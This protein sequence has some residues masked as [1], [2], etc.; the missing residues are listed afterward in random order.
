MR[1]NDAFPWC[2]FDAMLSALLQHAEHL[3]ARLCGAARKHELIR[4][5]DSLE[6]AGCQREMCAPWKDAVA[7]HKLLLDCVQR[8]RRKANFE[9]DVVLMLAAT[10]AFER[11]CSDP[12]TL[13]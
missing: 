6:Q 10:E 5:V 2:E 11:F 8:Q 7:L 13:H 3:S 4:I 12:K 9:D 1:S